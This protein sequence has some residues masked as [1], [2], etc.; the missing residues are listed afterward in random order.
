[1]AHEI[2][3]PHEAAKEIGCSIQ[4]VRMKMQSGDW[5]LGIVTSPKQSGKQKYS[6]DI[7][8]WKLDKFLGR[9]QSGGQSN[10]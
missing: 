9:D 5:D 7:Q 2:L 8:R 10:G 4:C 3:K 6:Y 1:M